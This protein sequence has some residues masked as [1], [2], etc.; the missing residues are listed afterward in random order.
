MWKH[1]YMK[2]V[3]DKSFANN[4]IKVNDEVSKSALQFAVQ[5]E[6]C[7]MPVCMPGTFPASSNNHSV[8][9]LST[10]RLATRGLNCF[11]F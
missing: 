5:T 1:L 7:Q 10:H 3:E 2:D 8:H 4:T 9:R 6:K 11:G